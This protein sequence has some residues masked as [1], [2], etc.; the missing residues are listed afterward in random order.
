MS[1]KPVLVVDLDFTLIKTDMLMETV[2]AAL[3]HRFSTVFSIVACLFSGRAQLK[4]RLAETAEIDPALLPYN[5]TV[6]EMIRTRRNEG[7]RIALATASDE[8]IARP[9]ADYLGL[10][11]E[12]HASD[13]KQN[14]K[15]ATK[16]RLLVEL[17][18]AGKF[19][20]I[21]DSRADLPV[22]SVSRQ[23]IS[24]DASRSLKRAID[25]ISSDVRHIESRQ[26][27]RF[28]WLRAM[29]PH[30]W[31]KNALVFV[32]AIA[33]HATDGG[34]W[35][36]AVLAFIAFSLVASSAYILNDLL[37]LAADRAD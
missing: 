15:G 33:A 24:I 20:Y 4:A 16:S 11:D 14:N 37:D 9:I 28:S 35:V 34:V 10:F 17:Y 3:A 2:W 29:R 8:K 31:L 21:G 22:W 5:D 26:S 12:V 25:Q 7:G 23:A 19:D 27:E 30:Q 13:G 1:E 18:G 36:E 32:P 6:L